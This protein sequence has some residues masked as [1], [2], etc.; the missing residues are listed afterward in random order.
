MGEKIRCISEAILN[1]DNFITLPAT[2]KVLY[3]YINQKTDDKGFCDEVTSIMR[4]L[5][6]KPKDLQL[7]IDRK[8]LIKM[9]DWLFLEKHFWINNRNLRKD[10]L[11]DSRY[12]EYLDRVVVKDNLV[13]SC[14]QNDDKMT[15]ID[16]SLQPNVPLTK[17]NITKHNITQPNLAYTSINT[18]DEL[19]SFLR[20]GK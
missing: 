13:Y 19:K 8:F 9:E 2:S 5:C 16:D 18:E 7:L 6:A 1:N 17:H 11:K 3:I 14:R 4:T 12:E 20:G 10:R 15:P